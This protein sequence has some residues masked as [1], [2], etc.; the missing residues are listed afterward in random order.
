MYVVEVVQSNRIVKCKI[1][2]D[3]YDRAADVF[4]RCRTLPC[5]ELR[6]FKASF[7]D[8]VLLKYLIKVRT[9]VVSDAQS[10][11]SDDE[12]TISDTDSADV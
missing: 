9:P 1:R 11:A 4:A 6:L 12:T 7:G 8:R 3:D 10:T 2:T 5:R